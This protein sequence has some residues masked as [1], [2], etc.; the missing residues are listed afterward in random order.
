MKKPKHKIL[1]VDDEES[2]RETLQLCLE[3]DNHI[4]TASNGEEALKIFNKE[5]PDL[6]LTD[7]KMPHMNG[8]EV[9][10]Q[11]KQIKPG[12][13]II[14]ITAYDDTV[15]TIEAIK[16]GALDFIPKPFD[17]QTLKSFVN[18]ALKKN[19]STVKA[20][21]EIGGDDNDFSVERSLIGKTAAMRELIKNIGAVTN[22]KIN[23]LL[24]GENGTVKEV[25]A[26]VIHSAGITKDQPFIGVNCTAVSPMLFE[27]ELFGH[28]KGSFTGAFRAHKG[29][30][31]LAAEGTLFL[32]EISEMPIDFQ[33]KFLRVLQ[34]RNFER[35]GG[36]TTIPF[37]ARVIAATNQNLESLVA[38]NK[39]RLDLYHRLKIIHF[40]I[41]P[42][43]ERKEDIPALTIALLKKINKEL[44]KNVIKIPFEVLEILKE[45]NWPGNVRE[46][47]NTLRRAVTL[48]K[49]D[50]IL[51]EHLDLENEVC[52]HPPT[53]QLLS[54]AEV[55]HRHIEYILKNINWNKQKACKI[56][57]ITKPTLLKKIKEYNIKPSN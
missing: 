2:F 31:E 18:N 39:F 13:P 4:I 1:I 8:M 11:L 32:D 16:L 30:F 21:I 49:G 41:P 10:R 53:T 17:V 28:E 52:Q 6:V 55:E 43:R 29:K 19:H 23:I 46:L 24:E 14:M 12:I 25:V 44:N 26:R 40:R 7:Y 48:A 33:V 45:R 9:I 56:L 27:S 50:T 42:L 51:E 5:K 34:E 20:S 38:Q 36:E 57:G 15:N 22:N 47:E 37:R 54:L 3:E 35:V